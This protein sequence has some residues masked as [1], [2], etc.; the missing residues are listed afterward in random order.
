LHRL[1]KGFQELEE[2]RAEAKIAHLIV[3]I[4]LM[5][6]YDL[7][8]KSRGVGAIA[9]DGHTIIC[10]ILLLSLFMIFYSIGGK[11]PTRVSRSGPQTWNIAKSLEH[12]VVS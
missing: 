5:E 2:K 11:Y 7:H 1:G 12:C 4:L 6:F 9:S 10:I 8:L 3:Q